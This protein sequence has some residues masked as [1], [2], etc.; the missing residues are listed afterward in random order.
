MLYKGYI[1]VKKAACP[2][3]GGPTEAGGL[4]ASNLP[5]ISI[6]HPTRMPDGPAK[7]PGKNFVTVQ[8]IIISDTLHDCLSG[9]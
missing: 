2:F 5:L 3:E 7:R 8:Y 9:L 6:H 4:S 1:G